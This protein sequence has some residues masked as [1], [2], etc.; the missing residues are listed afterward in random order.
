MKKYFIPFSY[1]V[2]A[3]SLFG[4]IENSNLIKI[5]ES[6][7]NKIII[8]K[9]AHVIPTKRQLDYLNREYIA[10]IHFGVNTFN[11]VEWGNGFEDPA[12]FAP[13]SIDTDQWCRI[14]K[15]AGMKLVVLTVKHHDGFCLWPSRYTNHSVASSPD[16][17]NGN[18]DVFKELSISCE[19][20]GLKLGVYLSPADL[21]QIESSEGLYG[22][23]SEYRE[24]VI[25]RVVKNRPFENKTSF[26]FKVDDYNEYFLNQLF[27]LLTEYGPI[28]EVWFDGA[29]P[30]SKGGQKYSYN[31]WYKLIRE[32]TPNA[33]IFGKGPDIRWCGNE[34]GKTRKSEWNVIP[35]Q[36]HPTNYQ[37]DDLT[38]NDLGSNNKLYGSKYLYYLPAETNTSIRHGW[39][40]RDDTKQQ[41]RSAT[42]VFDIYERSVGGNSV[43]MLNIPP[44][45]NGQISKRDEISLVESGRRIRETYTDNLVASSINPVLIDNDLNSSISDSIITIGVKSGEIVN[46]IVLQEATALYG[47]RVK[48]FSVEAKVDGSWKEICN[49]TIIGFKKIIR[50]DEIEASDFKIIIKGSRLKAH[51]AEV[52]LYYAKSYPPVVNI[53]RNKKGVV[54]LSLDKG[55][56]SWKSYA[57]EIH[58]NDIE[59][60]YTLNGES[61]NK[62]SSLKYNKPFKL[63]NGGWLKTLA[64]KDEILGPISELNFGLSSDK[65]KIKIVK[66]ARSEV[67]SFYSNLIDNNS[68]TSWFSANNLPQSLTYDMKMVKNFSGFIWIPALNSDN[69][70]GLINLGIIEVSNNGESWKEVDTFKFGNIIN[71]PSM[72]IHY[73]EDIIK[74]RYIRITALEG[75]GDIKIFGA[76]ELQIMVE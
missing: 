57:S 35:L 16:Y 30:K 56:F 45:R 31:E 8:E 10:F 66:S 73:L 3:F 2:V 68:S 44:N 22:N 36:V 24:R 25:P 20:Y 27:E 58:Q 5:E 29:T 17:E 50:F 74:C 43:F 46:R 14:I 34:G 65:C 32:L 4:Q 67:G 69:T 54:S 52:G 64:I 60:Y 63:K 62:T 28:Y 76:S 13:N 37:W 61:P 53:S 40:F 11:S 21:Y 18:G 72:R 7:S 47:Q 26:K 41:V 75:A 1:M 49:E 38:A 6:D 9:A 51:I 59:I 33:S 48:S 42:D 70:K 15:D 39:F 55:N 71:D 12:V 23:L 19:K